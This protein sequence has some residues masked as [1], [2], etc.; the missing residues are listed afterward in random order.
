MSWKNK[1][2]YVYQY[3]DESNIPYYIGKGKRNRIHAKHS[4][5]L[6][7]SIEQRIFIKTNLT[8]EDALSLEINLIKHY[9]RKIDGGLLDN[10]KDNQWACTTGW[11]HNEETKRKISESTMGI[12]KSEKTKEKMRKPKSKDHAEKIRQANLGRKDDGRNE[13]ISQTMSL[14]RWYNNGKVS[15]MFMPGQEPAEFI[16]GRKIKENNN[17]LA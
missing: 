9:G 13:K 3:V 10:I 6:L 4:N 5:T 14:K 11:N 17:V 1:I 2:F 16:L 7:P 12:V 15:K 8:E